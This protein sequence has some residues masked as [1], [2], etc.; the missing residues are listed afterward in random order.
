VSGRPQNGNET[1]LILAYAVIIIII[2]FYPNVL[3]YVFSIA[4]PSV[5]RL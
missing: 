4:N 5:C 3:R 1:R 2:G